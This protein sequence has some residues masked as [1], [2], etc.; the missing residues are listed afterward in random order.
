MSPP[1]ILDELDQ[2]GV[3]LDDLTRAE[4]R[5]LLVVG[6]RLRI[7]WRA[8]GSARVCPSGYVG[9]VRLSPERAVVVTTKVPVA[10]VLGLASLAYGSSPVPPSYGSGLYESSEPSDWVALLLISEVEALLSVGLR[11]GYV[12]VVEDLPYVRGR[13]RFDATTTMRTRTG[14]ATC[15]FSDF[16]AD[17]AENRVLRATL[18]FLATRRLLPGLRSRLYG[19]L[20]VFGSVSLVPATPALLGTT[21]VTRLNRHY[22]PALDLCRIVLSNKGLEHPGVD[23]IAPAFFFPMEQVFEAA[24]ANY[25]RRHMP[26]VRAQSGRSINAVRGQPD[27]PLTYVPDI[28]IGEPAILV[29]D[30]KYAR[31]EV[32]NA[33]GGLSFSNPHAYQIA[34]YAHALNCPG[35]LV[36][37][38]VDRDVATDFEVLGTRISFLTVDLSAPGLS[39]LDALTREL[40]RRLAV[41]SNGAL[42]VDNLAGRH[43]VRPIAMN[44]LA[45]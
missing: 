13:M 27:H 14:L 34:F 19:L 3:V 12:T 39:G 33:Y 22:G 36:Y 31:P 21:H 38:R 28:T 4:R 2:D 1:H 7:E 15:E 26:G 11:Q 24:V 8:D 37:P 23:T 25:L 32:R 6:P 41:P 35:A 30:T 17:T 42:V 20:R 9:S 16:I 29:L 40:E 43:G 44:R 10:N 18:E 45:T 5:A